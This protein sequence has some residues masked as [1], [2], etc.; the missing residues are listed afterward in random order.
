MRTTF[1]AFAGGGGVV[2][3]VAVSLR[4]FLRRKL[5]EI[6]I[7]TDYAG[8]V[9]APCDPFAS[10]DSSGAPAWLVWQAAGG[11][12]SGSFKVLR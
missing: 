8:G 2:V 3:V 1:F 7:T 12:P 4:H 10:S 11:R 6:A 5:G 9:F